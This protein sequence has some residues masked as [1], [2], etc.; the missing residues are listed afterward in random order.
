MDTIDKPRKYNALELAQMTT[1]YKRVKGSKYPGWA[2]HL[3]PLNEK[4]AKRIRRA[5][6][7]YI[8]SQT[9]TIHEGQPAQD[10]ATRFA[11]TWTTAFRTL[12]RSRLKGKNMARL[13]S[14]GFMVFFDAQDVGR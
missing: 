10:Q 11:N 4:Q 13:M 1:R 7:A 12:I 3:Q 14:R 6:R 9:G 2:S 8:A 5:Q